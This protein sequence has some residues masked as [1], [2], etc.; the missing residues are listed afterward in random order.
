MRLG[1][2]YNVF[3]GE[4]LLENAI[5]HA[6]KHI[7][8]ISVVYQTVSYFGN[9]ANESLLKCLTLLKNKNYIDLLVE[10]K[11]N[12]NLSPKENE[13]N[14]RNTGLQISK[15]NGCTHHISADVDEFYDNVDFVKNKMQDYDSS[16]VY[17]ENYFKFSNYQ[18]IPSQN[19]QTTFIHSVKLNYKLEDSYPYKIDI[20]RRFDNTDNCVVV[21][22]QDFIIH[23]MSYVRKNI[24]NKIYN[25]GNWIVGNKDKFI[26][27]YELYRLGDNV[28]LPPDFIVRQTKFVEN[29]FLKEEKWAQHQ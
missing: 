13:V 20:T 26:K 3:D 18:V 14:S 19:H 7:D 6:R 12:L 24:K 4:E 27:D 29:N 17:L 21:G 28:K 16:V 23:H 22:K 5:F 10:Y 1:L 8:F 15:E 11:N 25:S 2:S 9:K